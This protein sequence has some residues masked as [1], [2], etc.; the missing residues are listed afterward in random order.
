MPDS[1]KKL[2]IVCGPT[3]TGKTKLGVALAK[4]LNGEVVSAD[5]MQ[6]YRG[7]PIG[8]AQPTAEEM[9]GIPHHMMAIAD[10]GEN[11][12]VARYVE[13][14]TACVEEIFARGKQPIVVGGTG[15]YIDALCKG[16]TFSDFQ[17]DSGLRAKLQAQ[18]AQGGLPRLRA[19]LERIDPEAAARLHPNDEK[20]ILRALEV[21][22]TTGKTISQHNRETQAR[23][24]RYEALTITLT[25]ADRQALYARIDRRVDEMLRQGLVQ[26]IE[27]LLAAGIPKDG[28]AMQAI[29]YKELVPAVA[30]GDASAIK[31]A[32]EEVKLRSRQYAK[33]QLSWFRRNPKAHWIAVDQME[34]SSSVVVDSTDFLRENGVG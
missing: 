6:I 19:D 30:S 2:V 13:E 31:T 4:A 25:Y 3:A 20:R 12:S 34:N 16:Q 28:T 5:S 23:P 33:R 24:P 14:A 32:A 21:W 11:Y 1:P 9:A 29:G 7:M 27:A 15:L 22:Y 18:A 8:T 10:P 26:E 17:P